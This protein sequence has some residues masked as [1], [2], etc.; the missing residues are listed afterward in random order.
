VTVPQRLR[1]RHQRYPTND[2]TATAVA[3]NATVV[4]SGNALDGGASRTPNDPLRE[5]SFPE[6]SVTIPGS[7]TVAQLEEGLH[8][9]QLESD[10]DFGVAH[11]C[12][13]K[14]SLLFVEPRELSSLPLR[15]KSRLKRDFSEFF[16]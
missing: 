2:G 1:R 4:K 5:T 9:C 16:Q 7:K 3:I 6:V 14:S 15:V 11:Q 10:D 12:Q 8:Q 13:Q